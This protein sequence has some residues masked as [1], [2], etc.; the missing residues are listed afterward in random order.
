MESV[1]IGE[2]ACSYC[3]LSEI[4][5]TKMKSF[6][7]AVYLDELDNTEEAKKAIDEATGSNTVPKV[8]VMG[9]GF[10]GGYSQLKYAVKCDKIL[11]EFS[12]ANGGTDGASAVAEMDEITGMTTPDCPEEPAG[13]PEVPTPAPAP[14]PTPAPAPAP[15][16]PTDLCLESDGT[17]NIINNSN[18]A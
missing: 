5:L 13:E 3:Y 9:S 14:T 1:V 18:L 6:T 15:T 17:T 2:D 8:F 10:I 11:D 12:L 4:L 16:P 7:I